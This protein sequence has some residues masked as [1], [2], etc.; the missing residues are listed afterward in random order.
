MMRYPT[1]AEIQEGV[2]KVVRGCRIDRTDEQAIERMEE[3]CMGRSDKAKA[4]IAK[5]D[6]VDETAKEQERSKT[7]QSAPPIYRLTKR[8]KTHNHKQHSK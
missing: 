5:Y 1:S 4:K 2:Q 8:Q 7:N 6:R 3:E